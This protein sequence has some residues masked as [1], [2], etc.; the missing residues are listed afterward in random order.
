MGEASYVV[1]GLPDPTGALAEG[2]IFLVIDGKHQQPLVLANAYGGELARS[3]AGAPDRQLPVCSDALVYRP[4]G[5]RAG[6]VRRVRSVYC[7]ELATELF[8]DGRSVD[9]ARASAV[10][11]SIHGRQPLADMLA[12]GDYDGE[13]EGGEQHLLSARPRNYFENLT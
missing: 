1:M 13:Q 2:E 9:P 3:P 6:D 12:G 4:P 8:G 10:Y 7:Q 5:V 11:F